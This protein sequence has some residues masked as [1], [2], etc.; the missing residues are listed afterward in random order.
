MGAGTV[1]AAVAG[2][3]CKTLGISPVAA[4]AAAGVPA[5]RVCGRAVE[6]DAEL[7]FL[8]FRLLWAAILY[9]FDVGF[10]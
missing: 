10:G 4:A 2:R 1:E 5:R 6:G 9:T 3:Y 7:L 8:P